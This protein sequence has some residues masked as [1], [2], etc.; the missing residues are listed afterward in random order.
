MPRAFGSA[1]A[2][3]S[4]SLSQKSGTAN[5]P[6][7][8]HAGIECTIDL[9]LDFGEPPRP[10]RIVIAYLPR[11]VEHHAPREHRCN[12]TGAGKGAD[13]EGLA[14]EGCFLLP[15]GGGNEILVV[16]RPGWH[17]ISS[18]LDP[19]FVAPSGSVFGAPK[20]LEL[21]LATA[22]RMATDVAEAGSLSGWQE[23]IATAMSVPRC[24]HWT[25]G[26]LGAFAGPIVA[27]TVLD[28]CG[29]N[30]SGLT[31]SG[32]SLGQRV[33]V[34]AWSSPDI[35]RP[36]LFQSARTTDNAVE[37]LAQRATGTVLSLEELSHISGKDA[38]NMIYTIASGAGKRRM[39]ADT[40]IRD[41][42]TWATFVILSGECS[43]EE[44]IRADG[45][46]WLAGMAV[47]IV[48]IDVTGVNRQV[49]A[50]TLRKINDHHYR[51]AG[52]IFVRTL[53]ERGGHRQASELRDR[54]LKA[55]TKL[56]GENADSAIVRAAVPLALL[57]I[58]GEVAK[59]FDLIPA[60]TAVKEAVRW[61]GTA[62]VSLL[63][64]PPPWIPRC[65]WSVASA[66]GSPSAG[67]NDQ[68]RGC[69]G[70]HQQSRNNRLV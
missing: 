16:R 11:C 43:L 17:E 20:D 33:A 34:S 3:R 28:T 57:M 13:R 23:A 56:A 39:N 55:A 70:W 31:S 64:P 68:R 67:G 54:I 26:V 58:A 5:L 41:T 12:R 19:I 51:H 1:C 47:R 25:L 45:G 29:M 52:P 38:V 69:Q 22:I 6:R 18:R 61:G 9:A 53:I 36:G 37:V 42:Y 21:E 48:D 50:A 27:L 4:G 66:P 24:E 63:M 15:V 8:L 7:M 14:V 60:A 35:R 65:K 2:R 49:D 40:T 62:S 30:L 32:K 46:D 44:K 59:S 10:P